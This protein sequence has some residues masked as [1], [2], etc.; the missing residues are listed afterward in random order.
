MPKLKKGSTLVFRVTPEMRLGIE[1]L[2]AQSRREPADY[3]RLLLE[4][5]IKKE[6]QNRS[7][8][9]SKND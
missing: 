2:A 6:R 8:T 3:L 9:N 7:Q 1:A 4:D 5:F